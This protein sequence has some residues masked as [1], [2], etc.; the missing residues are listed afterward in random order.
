LSAAARSHDRAAAFSSVPQRPA[1]RAAVPGAGVSSVPGFP[2]LPRPASIDAMTT[3]GDPASPPA[4]PT[5]ALAAW[6][7][8]EPAGAAEWPPPY[9]QTDDHLS[10]WDPPFDRD[11]R[12]RRTPG[13]ITAARYLLGGQLIVDSVFLLIAI[14]IVGAAPSALGVGTVVALL[15]ALVVGIPAATRLGWR[16]PG[17]WAGALG[18]VLL[19]GLGS[20]GVSVG[21]ILAPAQ[22]GLTGFAAMTVGIPFAVG[23]AIGELA[24]LC[25]SSVPAYSR[26]Q[27]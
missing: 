27:R 22:E 15:A 20:A 26:G 24:L 14:A 9:P 10:R 21:M 2:P 11:G 16:R 19:S 5:S 1:G 6:A 8:A 13:T 25:S 3:W 4:D 17:A 18:F 7:Q 12:P 23:C